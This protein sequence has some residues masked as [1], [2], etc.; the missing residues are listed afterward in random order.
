MRRFVAVGLL[1]ALFALGGAVR[2]EAGED[3]TIEESKLFTEAM[4]AFVRGRIEEGVRQIM[5]LA[6]AG[7]AFAQFIAGRLFQKG[8]GVAKDACEALK[9]YELAATQDHAGAIKQLGGSYRY[10]LC[11]PE[12]YDE[13]ARHYERAIALG[14]ISAFGSLSLLYRESD[15]DGYNP[16]LAFETMKQAWNSNHEKTADEM[17]EIAFSLGQYYRI[18]IGV[19]RDFDTAERYL[20][21]AANHGI[22]MAQSLLSSVY[23]M[24]GEFD[25]L[26][27]PG[28]DS[29]MWPLMAYQQAYRIKDFFTDQLVKEIGADKH[30]EILEK[31]REKLRQLA[32]APE[33][34]IG[35]AAAWCGK[36]M[37]GSYDCLRY[38]YND[39]N[40]CKSPIVN[41]VR[42]VRYVDSERYDT[43]RRE[44]VAARE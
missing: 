26:S 41:E 11:R 21:L 35:R 43:C 22:I 1:L 36:A 12:N 38:A 2:L 42:G 24:R 5:P 25:D 27:G 10:G 44:I 14:E 15:W 33:S 31:A 29:L 37:A 20:L 32:A 19:D 13:A 28:G 6:E 7:D 4:T 40:A 18:G 34:V 23:V 8:Y 17:M 16:R 30:A 3:V 9:W 39:H